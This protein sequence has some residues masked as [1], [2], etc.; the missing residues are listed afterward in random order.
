MKDIPTKDLRSLAVI[1]HGACGKTSL[2]EAL[3]FTAGAVKTLGTVEAGSTVMDFEPEEHE[4]RKSLSSAI[5]HLVW[6]KHG[7]HIADTPGD[8]NFVPEARS[9]L[10]VLDG[11]LLVISAVSGVEPQ[12]EK[13]W[14]YAREAARPA[15]AFVNMMD[16]ENADFDKAVASL[17]DLLGINAV[18]IQI[19][20]GSGESFKGIVDLISQKAFVYATDG[21]G[22][23]KEEEIP[24]DLQDAA[25]AAR[26]ELLESIAESNDDLLEKYLESEELD[27]D[28]IDRGLAN[29]TRQG[30]FVPVACGSA[31]RDVGLGPL[32]DAILRTLPSP[33]Q[34][35]PRAGH[36]AGATDKKIERAPAESEPFSAIVFKT[37]VDPFA[38]TL[39]VMRIVSGKLDADL[40]ALNA[41]RGNK[42]KLAH[43]LFLMGKKQLAAEDPGP[44][45]IVAVAK[46]KDTHT[47]DTLCDEKAPVQYSF[48]APPR[49]VLAYALAAK[50]KQDED[51][52][53]SCL[54][55]LIEEDPSLH[56]DRDSQTKEHLLSG[57]GQQHIDVTIEK[58]KRKFGVEVVLSTPT[59]PY[60]ETVRGKASA[61][62]KLKKQTGG[63]GQFAVAWLELSPLP[64][65]KGFE[66]EDRIV[67]GVIPRNFIPAVEKGLLD[68]K[69]HGVLAGFPVVDFKAAVFDGKHH[70]V[71]SSEIAFK[72]AASFGFK[73]AMQQ[74]QPTI[75]EPIMLMEIEVP[76][77]NV[78]DVIGDLNARRGR[79]LGVDSR[80]GHQII[81]AQA[82]M[83]EVLTYAQS[84]TSITSGKGSFSMDFDH[85]DEA[86]APVREKIIA[87]RAA[88]KEAESS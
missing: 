81:K 52:V 61:E 31:T 80:G 19:P 21:S 79:V 67:G 22:K 72:L 16:R 25:K 23:F 9:C 34:A 42:E 83:A 57:M 54:H 26:K 59:V 12:T 66:F 73:A 8:S 85:Y 75:L 88:K 1:G 27:A 64:R 10:E 76:E 70:P 86:P 77:E 84:L 43:P 71:D 82:P 33:E 68:A 24:A 45:D 62:G 13:T 44:G 37:L 17:R 48:P 78:G 28:E 65:G 53:N 18:P 36:E 41:G 51:K 55:R 32:L 58:L 74:A 35:G 50:T 56:L 38:G 60:K 7:L 14:T 63:H 2:C 20:I 69:E 29:A 6:K 46:L 47:G 15:L 39:S 40:H 5:A 49:G 87:E 30:A 11:A 4:R 3:L